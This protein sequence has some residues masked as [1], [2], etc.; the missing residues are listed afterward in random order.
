MLAISES[1]CKITTFHTKDKTKTDIYA[2]LQ[3]D[4]KMQ[5]SVI[6]RAFES[7]RATRIALT[8]VN[9]RP[10]RIKIEQNA[11]LRTQLRK[12]KKDILP[13]FADNKL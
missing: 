1:E 12:R 3:S 7:C 11:V 8:Y 10:K 13:T 2:L 6:K 9:I 4:S 5:E